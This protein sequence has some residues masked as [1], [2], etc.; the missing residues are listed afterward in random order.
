LLTGEDLDDGGGD[1]HLIEGED[2]EVG[3]GGDGATIGLG[4]E[5]LFGAGGLGTG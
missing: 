2:A 5:A 3:G 1:L 4:E